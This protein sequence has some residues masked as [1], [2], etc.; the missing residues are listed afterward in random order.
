[1]D[2]AS[3]LPRQLLNKTVFVASSP[4]KRAELVA[5][6]EAMGGTVHP[7]PVI[8]I[9]EIEDK[10]PLDQALSCLKEYAWIIFTSAY[11]VIHFLQRM[12]ELGFSSD[13]PVGIRICA[14]G[15]ATAQE[16]VA[17]GLK[18]TLVP[19]QYVAE[20]VTQALEEHHGGLEFLAGLRVLLPRAKEARDV[21]PKTLSKAGIQVDVVPC[22]QTVR[23][24]LQET[25]VRQLRKKAPDLIVFTSSSTV[26][27]FVENFEP[28]DRE[29]MLQKAIVAALGPITAGT[30]AS[31]G[32]PADIVPVQNTVTALLEAIGNYYSRERP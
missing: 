8:E 6:L 9:L 14:I 25:T 3:S 5:G 16:L 22:Y 10:G 27:S 20:G 30:I 32:K 29:T 31:F 21:L 17:S 15:P 28:A 24:E 18:V 19:K 4:K 7:L 1:M 13:I 2:V 26:R 11:G 23:T 12:R